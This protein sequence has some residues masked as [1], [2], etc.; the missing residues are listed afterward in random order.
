[1]SER[2]SKLPFQFCLRVI[3]LNS[4]SLISESKFSFLRLKAPISIQLSVRLDVHPRDSLLNVVG[5][6]V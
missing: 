2:L 5:A 1:M 3:L 6:T 4:V